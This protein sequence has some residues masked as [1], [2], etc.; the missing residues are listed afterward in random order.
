M[1]LKLIKSLLWT[2]KYLQIERKA[3]NKEIATNANEKSKLKKA[4]LK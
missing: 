1:K 3:S 2:Y 4:A